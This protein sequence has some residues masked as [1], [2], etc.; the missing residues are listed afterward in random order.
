[1]RTSLFLFIFLLAGIHISAQQDSLSKQEGMTFPEPYH[2]NVIKLNPTP[3]LLLGEARNITFSYERLLNKN[4]SVAVQA[5][6]LLFPKLVDDTLLG[7][8]KFTGRSKQGVNLAFDYRYY[9]WQRN[10]RPVPDGLYIGGYVSYYGFRFRNNFDILKVN[11]DE[12]GAMDGKINMVNAGM[13]LGYQFIFWERFSVDLILFGP[14]YTMRH[15]DLRIS[16]ALDKDEIGEISDELAEKLIER[17]PVL[18]EIYATDELVVTESTRKF[19]LGFRY[20]I[21][22]GF[23]F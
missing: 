5:G 14:S 21:Q 17:F 9:P 3:M 10:R 22:I 8:V 16:G 20:S 13:L 18:A 7:L 6:Y 2:K 15:T 1:M 11:I 4:Q 12:N 19:G 23:H